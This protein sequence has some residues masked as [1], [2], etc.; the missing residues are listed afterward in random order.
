MKEKQLPNLDFIFCENHLYD[1]TKPSYTFDQLMSLAYNG[2]AAAM[3]QL[4]SYYGL[5]KDP[6]NAVLWYKRAAD[7]DYPYAFNALSFAYECGCGV[8]KDEKKAVEILKDA[9]ARFDLPELNCHLGMM[10]IDGTGCHKDYKTGLTLLEK[11]GNNRCMCG[12][13]ALNIALLYFNGCEGIAADYEKAAKWFE[14][15]FERDEWQSVEY[16]RDIYAGRYDSSMRDKAKYD[17]WDDI[18]AYM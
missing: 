4:G 16:L 1:E 15:A 8:K 17:L 11:A 6:E 18:W 12:C 3:Y 10:F 9:V 13:V 5:Y 7:K 14:K 2:D